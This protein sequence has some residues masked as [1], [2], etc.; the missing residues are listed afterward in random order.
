MR[1]QGGGSM[2][3]IEIAINVNLEQR[4]RMIAGSSIFQRNNPPKAKLAQI[5]P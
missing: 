5:N 3:A 2:G 1:A 4:R